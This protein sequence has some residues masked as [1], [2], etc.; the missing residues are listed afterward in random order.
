[1]SPIQEVTPDGWLTNDPQ[2]FRL[3]TE[4][5]PPRQWSYWSQICEESENTLVFWLWLRIFALSLPH[6]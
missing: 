2:G 6:I 3:L 1:M 4:H 5:L